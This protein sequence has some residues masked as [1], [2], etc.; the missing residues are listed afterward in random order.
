[1]SHLSSPPRASIA[2]ALLVVLALAAPAAQAASRTSKFSCKFPVI[3]TTPVVLNYD[4]PSSIVA[5]EPTTAITLTAVTLDPSVGEALGGAITAEGVFVASLLGYYREARTDVPFSY[6][7]AAPVVG[8]KVELDEV[9][10]WQIWQ[11]SVRLNVT[12]RD[13]AGDPIQLQ[14][15][16]GEDSDGNPDTFDV[17]CARLPFDDVLTRIQV[18]EPGN[19]VPVTPGAIKAV[20]D[21]ARSSAT[22][23]WGPATDDQGIASYEVFL[24]DAKIA[25]VPG[26][27]TSYEITGL[28]PNTDLKVG[29]RAIDTD[30][31]ASFQRRTWFR[32]ALPAQEEQR[33]A[34]TTSGNATIKTLTAGAIPLSGDL[35][36]SSD[37]V[38]TVAGDLVL[39]PVSARLVAVGFLPVTAKL[40]FAMAGPLT[41]FWNTLGLR[42]FSRVRIKVVEAKL[43][44]AIPLA[45]GNNCQTRQLTELEL[46]APEFSSQTG[47]TLTGSFGISDLNGCGVLNG[48]VSPSTASTGNTI[49]LNA[50]SVAP[51]GNS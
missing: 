51:P 32:S 1:M 29:V 33:G 8:P 16:G 7:L 13:A 28:T 46:R 36:V 40:A 26:T 27:Q 38:G 34:F 45:A 39:N 3:G 11:D 42:T 35:R 20:T 14:P 43:F 17:N 24:S 47:G 23:T 21:P 25:S 18:T 2:A 22:I 49:T 5:G 12:A 50:T 31:N 6:P 10:P 19:G 41:G 44:G 4:Y 30:G 9:N 15:V 48:L 37:I